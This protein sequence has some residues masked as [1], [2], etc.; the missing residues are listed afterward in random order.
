MSKR[1]WPRSRFFGGSRDGGLYEDAIGDRHIVIALT[2][3]GFAKE[4]YVRSGHNGRF[5]ANNP[6][7]P[8]PDLELHYTLETTEDVTE[9]LREA[10]E[11]FR[12]ET[13]ER[14]LTG[15]AGDDE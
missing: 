4:T 7:G 15:M 3:S 5:D 13:M 12:A 2:S 9:Q 10:R 6:D 14:M 1:D 11:R 8:H